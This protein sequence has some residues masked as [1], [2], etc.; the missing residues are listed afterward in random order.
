M[1]LIETI[2]VYFNCHSKIQ[3]LVGTI[4]PHNNIGILLKL[5]FLDLAA[6]NNDTHGCKRVHNVD[7]P[8]N[9]LENTHDA[10]QE[11]ST[12]YTQ[13]LQCHIMINPLHYM[14]KKHSAMN[15]QNPNGT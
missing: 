14:L 2:V 9:I 13:D 15:K 12:C 11:E 5:L 7:T 1:L 3:A 6:N 8:S 10:C 4:F